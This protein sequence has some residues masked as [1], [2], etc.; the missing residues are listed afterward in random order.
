[1][2]LHRTGGQGHNT[3]QHRLPVCA[4]KIMNSFFFS[5]K[6]RALVNGKKCTQRFH[7]MEAAFSSKRTAKAKVASRLGVA[8]SS[9]QPLPLFGVYCTTS[10]HVTEPR[11]CTP[12]S[13]SRFF[14]SPL[15]PP[16]FFLSPPFPLSPRYAFSAPAPRLPAGCT[17]LRLNVSC[18]DDE[19]CKRLKL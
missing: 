18:G 5:S 17:V 4:A 14:P 11:L 10:H 8:L 12:L 15:V 19:A 16:A 1:M 7:K 13:H 6:K 3:R 2:S 9:A